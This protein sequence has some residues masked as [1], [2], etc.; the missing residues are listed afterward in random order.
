MNSNN[1]QSTTKSLLAAALLPLTLHATDITAKLSTEVWS[2][3]VMNRGFVL[4]TDPYFKPEATINSPI[5]YAYVN[6]KFDLAKSATDRGSYIAAGTN[7]SLPAN[8]I[9]PKSNLDVEV[10]QL[11]QPNGKRCPELYTNLVVSAPLKPSFEAVVGGKDFPGKY[12]S[13]GISKTKTF[14]DTTAS[15]AAKIGY[16]DHYGSNYSAFSHA[17]IDASVSQQIAKNATIS[18]GVRAQI[19]IK[20]H[21]QTTQAY[22]VK[23]AHN[24]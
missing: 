6:E 17:T 9:S 2:Q 18:A 23:T 11:A 14:G 7:F 22:F 10:G 3:D 21:A 24:F 19:G 20:D 5:G 13:A 15:L 8:I 12:F 4:S 16:N 1:I